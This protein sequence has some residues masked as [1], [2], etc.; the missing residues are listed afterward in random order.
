MR[1]RGW[2]I[3]YILANEA[4]KSLLKSAEVMRE[5]G[6]VVSDHAPVIVDFDL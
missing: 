1:D 2:T 3:D 6:L 4:A 5:G